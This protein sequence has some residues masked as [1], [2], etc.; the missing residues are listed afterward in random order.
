MSLLHRL[1]SRDLPGVWRA[2]TR[3][4]HRLG[5]V[6]PPVAVQWITT[7]VCD[8]HCPHCYSHA[9]KKLKGELTA[10]EAKRLIVDE[11]V[12]LGSPTLVLAG[13]EPTLAR[14]F[15]EVVE[16][17]HR[18]GVPWAMH[19][20]GGRC[21]GLQPLFERC[22]P[23]MVAVSLDGP[24]GYHDAF[25]GRSGSFD[26]AMAAI[27]MFKTIGVGEVVAGTTVTRQNA[28][29]LL[30]LLPSV[31]SSGAD[32]WGLHLVTPEGRGGEHAEI[33]PTATQLRRVAH[34]ARRLRGGGVQV[35]AGVEVGVGV[36]V[37]LDNEWGSAGRDDAFYRDGRFSCGA[38]RVSC[39]ISATGEVVPC[40]TTDASESAGNVREVPLSRLW[41]EGFAPFRDGRDPLRGDDADCWLQTRHG[42]SCRGA[43]FFGRGDVDAAGRL[44]QVTVRA[45]YSLKEEVEGGTNREAKRRGRVLHNRLALGVTRAAA[46][47]AVAMGWAGDA[48]GDVQEDAAGTQPTTQ[49][50]TDEAMPEVLTQGVVEAWVEHR[51]GWSRGGELRRLGL[52]RPHVV[53]TGEVS[54]ASIASA[55]DEMERTGAMTPAGL[56]SL[57]RAS[58]PLTRGGEQGENPADAEALSGLYRR[59]HRHARMLD[60]LTLAAAERAAL[61]KDPRP[62]MS[63]AMPPPGRETVD[64]AA[65]DAAVAAAWAALPEAWKRAGPG[66]WESDGAAALMLDAPAGVRLELLDSDGSRRWIAHGERFTLHRLDVLHLP[67]DAGAGASLVHA[68]GRVEV[69]PGQVVTAW[70]LPDHLDEP[71]RAAVDAL[72]QRVAAGVGDVGDAGDEEAIDALETALPLA[73]PTI[74]QALAEQAEEE[75]S[76]RGMGALRLLLSQFEE[77]VV[78]VGVAHRQRL[79]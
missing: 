25:R 15:P 54:P 74:R 70:N 3:L 16:H 32:S 57:W 8:L 11:C 22:P 23:A 56:S 72:V 60:A 19:T 20:H 64:P 28:S 12:K 1:T 65:W 53:E 69:S 59:F 10:D 26:A 2:Q 55:L 67:G 52:H 66:L 38:G 62:W 14:A 79:R 17:A 47:V 68:L 75:D 29:I 41:A 73:H 42:R 13:G 40:T 36:K 58:E 51:S 44:H 77:A 37:E 7:A 24:R 50:S 35:G 48:V 46:V 9:G 33:L 49:P 63:K 39:V 6:R 34:L 18:R 31:R 71:G 30:D 45:G 78:E 76:P 27:R 61:R 5:R 21:L 4:L 43:A